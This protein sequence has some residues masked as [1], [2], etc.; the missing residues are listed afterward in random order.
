MSLFGVPGAKVDFENAAPRALSFLVEQLPG[1]QLDHLGTILKANTFVPLVMPV[2]DSLVLHQPAPQFAECNTCVSCLV[3][4]E[5]LEG[6]PYIRRTHQLPGVTACWRHGIE[7][8]DACPKCSR[9]FYWPEKFLAAPLIPCRCGWQAIHGYELVHGT[10]AAQRF[11]AHANAVLEERSRTTVSNDL[12][13]FFQLRILPPKLRIEK[14]GIRVRSQLA[15]QVGRHLANGHSTIDVA[16]AAAA[17]I[18]ASKKTYWW[19]ATLA[20]KIL[21][22]RAKRRKAAD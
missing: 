8:I 14:D 11:S 2:A 22:D 13:K 20:P 19:T 3:E 12:I 16:V 10:V 4:D 21:E 17:V 15:E 18:G 9:P 6:I 7:L 1:P 5:D